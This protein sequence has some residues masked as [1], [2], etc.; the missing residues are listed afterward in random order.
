MAFQGWSYGGFMALN[1]ITKGSEYIKVAIAVAPVSNWKFYDNIYTER[2]M[3]KPSENTAGYEDNSPIKYVKQI[4]G[5]LLLIHG[6]ADDNVH[7][8]NA[9]EFV[10]AAVNNNIPLDYFVY[11]NKNHG[12]FGGYTRLHLYNK[13]F[14]F[15]E[16][17]LK[18]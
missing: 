17:N 7:L 14:G 12:I 2:Y 3:R 16:S 11:P 15:L 10:N 6:A 18:N 13:I 5:K 8:Q 4:K 9:M 1:M